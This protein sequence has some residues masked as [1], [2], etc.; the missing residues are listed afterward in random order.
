[1]RQ[2]NS[3]GV[4]S[5][6]TATITTTAEYTM[7]STTRSPPMC[8]VRP[9]LAKMRPTSPRGI[10]PSPI[11]SRSAPLSSTPSEQAC[12]PTTAASVSTAANPSTP[13]WPNTARSTPMPM[14]TKNTGTRKPASGSMRWCRSR[15]CVSRSRSAS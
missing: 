12:L 3:G 13:G 15:L 5:V 4:T 10:M 9:M 6:V 1:M 14:S 2:T 8:S 11:A 7:S